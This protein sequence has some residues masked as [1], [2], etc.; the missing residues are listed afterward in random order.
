MSTDC[1]VLTTMA[2]S[3]PEILD[4]PVEIRQMVYE[5]LNDGLVEVHPYDEETTDGSGAEYL[6]TTASFRLSSA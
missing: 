2:A 6:C 4:L 3:T 5:H 1:A